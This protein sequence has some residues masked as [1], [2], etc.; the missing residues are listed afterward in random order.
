MLA[1]HR[2]EQSAYAAGAAEQRG[3]WHEAQRLWAQAVTDADAGGTD[4]RTRAA[5]YYEYGRAAGVTCMF[6]LAEDNLNKAYELD[7]QTSGPSFMSLVE[8]ARLNYDQKKYSQAVGYFSRAFSDMD[9]FDA[10]RR[11]PIGYADLL[12]EY[13]A[14]LTA[15]GRG[16]EGKEAK[17]KASSIRVNNQ[18]R[19][20]VTDRTPYGTECPPSPN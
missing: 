15:I 13:A 2:A 14:A 9:R 1:R 6:A 5:F 4:P 18:G 19:Y 11:E 20:S 17:A 12:D 8:L 16:L 3:N 10:S 7:V